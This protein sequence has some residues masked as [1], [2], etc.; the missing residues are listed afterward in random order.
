MPQI[1][2][3]FGFGLIA[4]GML[5]Y[6][7]TGQSSLTA[8]IPAFFGAGLIVF[9]LVALKDSLRKHAM[10]GAATVALVGVIGSLMRG[11]P[12]L[13]GDDPFRTAT[14]V[15]L[16]MGVALI[17]FMVLCVRSFIAARRATE[18]ME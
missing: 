13:L 6:F 2:L 10:H 9:G 8:M 16:V 5:S 15:Q 12:G 7:G 18:A 1:T 4:L 11:V 3:V 17:V 14:L